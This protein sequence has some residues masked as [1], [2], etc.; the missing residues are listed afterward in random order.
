VD[1]RADIYSLGCSLYYVLTG[2]PP[3]PEGTLSQRLMAHQKERPVAI[4]HERPDAPAD[5]VEICV[6]M[7]AKKPA[8]RYQTA[9]EVS[10]VL[11][12]WLA[13]H[14]HPSDSAK[15]TGSSS[16]RLASAAAPGGRASG[17]SDGSPKGSGRNKRAQGA[18]PA[19]SDPAA[20]TGS[21]AERGTLKG[22]PGAED[23]SA[24]R[25]S[26][27]KP[28]GGKKLLVARSLEETSAE[29]FLAELEETPLV[30]LRVAANARPASHR[31]QG[32]PLWVWAAIGGVALL[33]ILLTILLVML[34]G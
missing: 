34:P 21:S 27:P 8:D 23:S 19:R 12:Q 7:M 33:T 17:R 24:K 26:N 29:D 31:D 15:G 2:H 16:G 1:H 30:K 25:K 13:D 14:G 11:A 22:Q 3:F 9:D 20:E 6:R 32:V 10:E 18:R 4:T 5:L 28:P